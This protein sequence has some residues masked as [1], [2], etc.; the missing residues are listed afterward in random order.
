M[1][2]VDTSLGDPNSFGAS[3]VFALPFVRLFWLTNKDRLVRLF[4]FGYTGLSAL[5][6]LLTG[7]RSSLVGL[8]VCA[9]IIIMQSQKRFRYLILGGVLA[10]GA[11]VALPGDLQTRFETIVNSEVRTKSD[12]VSGYGRLEGL[13]RGW[14]LFQKYPL[15]GC[16]PGVWRKATGSDIESHNLYGQTMGELGILGVLTFGGLVV[17]FALG[18]RALRKRARND[19]SPDGEFAFHLTTTLSTALFLMLLEG[20]FG[21]NLFRFSWLWYIGFLLIATRALGQPQP[22]AWMMPQPAMRLVTR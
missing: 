11:F 13:E 1:I 3:I 19:S 14:D 9:L 5:C 17:M 2:G 7:S 12:T 4:L 6:I 16:G 15:T 18:L 10:C 8:L 21:H 22:Q 20:M